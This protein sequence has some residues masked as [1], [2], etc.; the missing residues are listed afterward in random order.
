[1]NEM[2]ERK[3][4]ERDSANEIVLPQDGPRD[5]VPPEPLMNQSVAA[6]ESLRRRFLE[7]DNS[8]YFR[9]GPGEAAKVA[10]SDHGK[11]LTTDHDDPTVIHGMV[12]RAQQK[13][14]TSLRVKGS[15]GFKVEVWIQA[16]IAGIEV[17]GYNPREIDRA[18][19][20]E[21]KGETLTKQHK[22]RSGQMA[23]RDR[24]TTHAEK[25]PDSLT[26]AQNIAITTLQAILRE[27]GDSA[28]MIGAAVQ[29]A[30]ARLHGERLVVGTIVEHGIAHYGHDEQAQK[31]YFVTVETAK[32]EQTVWGVDLARAIKRS[33]AKTGH[34]V[35]LIQRANEGVSVQ[36][37]I[38]TEAGEVAGM[39]PQP[40]KRKV[41]EV[42]NLNTIGLETRDTIDSAARV[43]SHEP[44]VQ[45]FD[46]TAART[47]Q[48]HDVA[49]TREQERTRAGR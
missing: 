28:A 48:V 38:R 30:T 23:T 24:S 11:R 10:F 41:W 2:P 12:L 7:A 15:E 22:N 47:D 31:S 39:G 4:R 25:K 20:D 3:T 5:T 1:M 19:L 42:L 34:A 18:R 45:V 49:R 33:D 36:S 13:G 43:A 27:R 35:A 8:F 26:A 21:R 14:W 6:A 32:G 37:P 29:E 16:T 17:E 40:A 44:V 46:R 9:A